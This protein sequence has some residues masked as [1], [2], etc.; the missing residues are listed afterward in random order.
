MSHEEDIGNVLTDFESMS[1]EKLEPT[2]NRL[3]VNESF[4]SADLNLTEFIAETKRYT[5]LRQLVLCRSFLDRDAYA[6]LLS[7]CLNND[8]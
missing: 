2:N 5:S 1:I 7:S 6:R 8:V 3:Q 4:T